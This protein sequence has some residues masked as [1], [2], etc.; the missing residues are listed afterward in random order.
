MKGTSVCVRERKGEGGSTGIKRKEKRVIMDK[1]LMYYF[2]AKYT[3][4]KS[5][6]YT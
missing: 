2:L 5:Q 1:T 4:S 6:S 3:R